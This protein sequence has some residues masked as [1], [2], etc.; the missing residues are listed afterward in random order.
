MDEE[1][2]GTVS[3]NGQNPLRGPQVG[4]RT[5]LQFGVAGASAL[6]LPSALTRSGNAA[7]NA[8]A[9]EVVQA[10]AAGQI[11][12]SGW[13]TWD[14]T[15]HTGVVHLPSAIQL[16]FGLYD[17]ATGAF[18]D[19]FTW[20]E[21]FA[22]LGPHAS[23]GSYCAVDVFW[24][25]GGGLE[26]VPASGLVPPSG[27]GHG[28]L[29]EYFANETLSGA[30]VATQ[31][32]PRIDFGWNG[33]PPV[34]GV[35]GSNWSARWTG[36]L[37]ATETGTY[38]LALTSDDG[39]RLYVGDK[40]AIDNWNVQ[41][42]TTGTARVD[43]AAGTPVPIRIEFF[44]HLYGSVLSFGWAPPSS[45][46][47]TLI[48]CEY[49]APD[50][51]TS[52]C[53]IT[54][55]EVANQALLVAVMDGAWD[56]SV[57]ATRQGG[58]LTG[59]TTS[60]TWVTRTSPAT[61]SIPASLADQAAIAV[62]L[63]GPVLVVTA[64]SSQSAV[65]LDTAAAGATLDRLRRADATGRLST[66]GW[67]QDAADGLVRAITWNT[68]WNPSTQQIVTPVS[69]DFFSSRQRPVVFEWDNF[70]CSMMAMTI[71]R[72]LAE[73]NF[74]VLLQNETADGFVPNFEFPGDG[75]SDD[76]SEP[77]VGAYCLLKAYRASSLGSTA[78]DRDLLSWAYPLLLRYHR[79]WFT[80]RDGN[81]D[82]LLEWGTKLDN[83]LQA[84]KYESGLDNSPMYDEAVFNNTSHTMQ[85]DDVGL[86]A[87][88]AADAWALSQIAAE[89]GLASDAQQL[90]AEYQA[91][92]ERINSQLW[93]E[94]TG[95]YLNRSWDGTFS[96]QLSPT[97]FYPLLAGIVPADRAARMAQAHLLNPS[98]FLQ[99]FMLPSIAQ[100]NP[101]YADQN[102]W[103]GRVWGPMNFLV[104]EGLRRY[105]L[106]QALGTLASS[107]LGLF[108]GE[109]QNKN[110]VHENYNAIIGS[111][112]D[113]GLS[114]SDPLYT[115]GALLAYVAMEQ[116]AAPEAWTGWSFGHADIPDA[117][118][119]NLQVAEGQLTVAVTQ[120]GL[121]VNLNNQALLASNMP[122]AVTG[123]QRNPDAVTFT[124]AARPGQRVTQAVLTVG[125]LP[126]NRQ[127]TVEIN[128]Q[129][130]SAH[131]DHNG[132]AQIH[133]ALPS[134]V[135]IKLPG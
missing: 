40:L 135:T 2:A 131:T 134:D 113:T 69:R 33:S 127:L 105:G 133:L 24:A 126:S 100:N 28:L 82:G 75:N 128:G 14:I 57:Q 8:R 27:Q 110:H 90:A 47:E 132:Q 71:D 22:S 61:T 43:L 87:L 111:G 59:T 92:G 5:V 62:P 10:P 16:R 78:A 101:A 98:E 50:D 42:P 55:R 97:L 91:T 83:N 93:N 52:I 19:G 45:P 95:I 32:D 58:T 103:R 107:G 94:Q 109:W 84:A 118:V 53:R 66:D 48:T 1:K 102:Y 80:A 85:L 11:R 44:Q 17:P 99:Q 74:T 12:A 60:G 119:R 81:N 20:H 36:S 37:A 114:E 54:P 104:A 112:D 21:G 31:T 25:N 38:T 73:A 129:T 124:A 130:Q 29:G 7:R 123:Y 51:A 115:W 89:L 120:R 65:P 72:S 68:V 64:P 13:N 49:G 88:Y 70:F 9:A 4:R 117:T 30:P 63:T 6:V 34:A 79:W 18:F 41:P 3:G 23:D 108:L 96:T 121:S 46:Y 39:S 56:S 76:R 67:L 77:P 106:H 125:Q 35:P 122:V 26:V 116:V 15:Y 86:N